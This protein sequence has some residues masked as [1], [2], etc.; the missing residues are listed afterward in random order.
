MTALAMPNR[1]ERLP[2]A[3]YAAD[4]LP[5]CPAPTLN[6][7]LAN[8]LLERSEFHSWWR[9]PRLNDEYRQEPPS[10]I[11]NLGS[12]AHLL[13]LEPERMDDIVRVPYEDWR[14]GA[15]KELRDR[16]LADGKI[17]L[18]AN[19]ADRAVLMA[20]RA[21]LALNLSPDLDGLGQTV[22]ELT[23]WWRETRVSADGVERDAFCRARPDMVSQ[24]GAILISYKTT[25]Q[26][27][28]PAAYMKT[29]LN[30]GHDLQ[31]AFE[32]SAVE[33]VERVRVSHYVWLVQETEEPYACSL[34]GM[35]PALRHLGMS[36]FDQAVMRWAEASATDYWPGYPSRIAYP[37][38]PSWRLRELEE[39]EA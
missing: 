22:S 5:G 9:H 25:G 20:Q 37:E 3:E 4:R 31:A 32:I 6:S 30:A 13:L 35:S 19:D 33:A 28:E 11:M 24:D 21:D 36:R 26:I 39:A 2:I 23:Y 38:V 7:S 15:A 10:N 1:L 18:L 34:I 12:A 16:A 29:L 8:R 17:P 14:T 27:A